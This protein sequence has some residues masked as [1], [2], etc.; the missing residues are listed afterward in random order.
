[1]SIRRSLFIQFLNSY[2]GTGI[3]FVSVVILAR[4]LTP[5]E[6]GVFSVCMAFVGFLHTL[7]DFGIG[8]YLLQERQL[9]ND[10]LRSAYGLA[11]LFAWSAGGILALSSGMVA[12]FF[13]E[14]GVQSVTLVLALNFLLIP[15][16][17]LAIP[18]LKRD[19][20]FISVM[21]INLAVTLAYAVATITFAALGVGYMSMAW[22]TLVGTLV[23]VVASLAA[24]PDL[25]GMRP[26]LRHARRIIS[27]GMY[28]VGSN[29]IVGLGPNGTEIVIGR[30]LGFDA[31][32]ML[33]KGRSLIT[34]FQQAIMAFIMPVAGAMFARIS[35]NGDDVGEPFLRV[36]SYL[37]AI[38]WP[39]F[40]FMGFMAF[41]MIDVLFGSQWYAAVP[42]AQIFC[43]A[44]CIALLHSLNNMT[45]EACGH[46][47]EAFHYQI[48]LYPP[49]ILLVIAAAPFGLLAVAGTTVISATAGL[50]LSYWFLGRVIH[51]RPAQI[52]RAVWKSALVAVI[53]SFP[54]MTV[55]FWGGIGPNN[56][57]LPLI[58]TAILTGAV[59]LAAI[60]ATGHEIRHEV[61]MLLRNCFDQ[62][63]RVLRPAV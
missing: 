2:S 10:V 52:A 44:Y 21:K 8:A 34:L 39:S 14:P 3:A 62:M 7:R 9:D 18:L 55:Y 17:S 25:I 38:G 12:D 15:L 32:A 37:T 35:R 51:I 61:V 30:M 45:L 40:I 28:S 59:W 56:A 47:K 43:F 16:G 49:A 24:R 53:S 58:G 63:R 5:Q 20:L 1:M 4:L 60:F 48:I 41:P 19:M 33:G 42:V 6:I 46:A 26:T 27:F 29:L 31:V 57:L 23:N 36:I 13:H 50:I 22:G 54:P 11:L